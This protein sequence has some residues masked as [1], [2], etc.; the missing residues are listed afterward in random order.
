[1]SQGFAVREQLQPGS[2]HSPAGFGYSVKPKKHLHVRA[3]VLIFGCLV[4]FD[5][6]NK[7]RV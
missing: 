2:K 6:G 3:H 4:C 5:T 1:M 7:R